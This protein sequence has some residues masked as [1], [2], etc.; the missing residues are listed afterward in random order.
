[1]GRGTFLFWLWT[2][3]DGRIDRK[4]FWLG[5]IPAWLLPSFGWGLFVGN[6]GPWSVGLALSFVGIL[7]AG[8]VI[9]KRWH[10]L[11]LW[12]TGCGGMAPA[13]RTSPRWLRT[14]T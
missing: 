9:T 12:S 4:T 8:A 11:G 14:R 1:M 2:S 3:F 13:G 6:E 10:D 7:A 5:F